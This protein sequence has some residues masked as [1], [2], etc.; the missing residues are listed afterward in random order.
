L[1]GEK[2]GRIV[3]EIM[4]RSFRDGMMKKREAK[5]LNEKKRNSY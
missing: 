4:R 2:G 3:L 5:D 1:R